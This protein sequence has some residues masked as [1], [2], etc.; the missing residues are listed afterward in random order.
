[1]AGKLTSL[2]K[3]MGIGKRKITMQYHTNVLYLYVTL[4]LRNT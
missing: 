3:P 4:T 1:M 2:R